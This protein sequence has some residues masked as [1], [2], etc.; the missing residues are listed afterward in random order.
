MA[1]L[2]EWTVLFDHRVALQRLSVGSFVV[3][4][5]LTWVHNAVTRRVRMHP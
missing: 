2:K 4:L 3:G 1:R 5:V